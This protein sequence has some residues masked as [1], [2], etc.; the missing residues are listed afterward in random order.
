M[1]RLA[2]ASFLEGSR[3]G[4]FLV[5]PMVFFLHVYE[6]QQTVWDNHHTLMIAGEKKASFSLASQHDQLLSININ[7]QEIFHF[8]EKYYIAFV[9]GKIFVAC[10]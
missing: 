4:S 3:P 2:G 10:C 9:S 8:D 6:Q 7:W 5:D 1:P